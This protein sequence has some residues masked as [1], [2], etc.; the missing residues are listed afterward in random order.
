MNTVAIFESLDVY[1]KAYEASLIIHRKTLLFP[2]IEQFALADQLRRATK[3]ICANL[4][5]GYAQKPLSVPDF[6][7]Y[8][9][10]AIASSDE[11]KVWV[12]YA[13]DLGYISQEECIAWRQTYQ[14]VAKMLNGIYKKWAAV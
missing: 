10:M 12:Q 11:V 1:R 9:G 2:R 14:D 6:R 5:E 7:R 4:A 13:F 3:S 8:L